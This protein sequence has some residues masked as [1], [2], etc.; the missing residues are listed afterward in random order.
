ML[1][2]RLMEERQ[3]DEIRR[4]NEIVA[5]LWDGDEQVKFSLDTTIYNHSSVAMLELPIQRYYEEDIPL[6]VEAVLNLVNKQ[7]DISPDIF[8][9]LKDIC[10]KFAKDA[11]KPTDEEELA[12]GYV[13]GIDGRLKDDLVEE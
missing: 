9:S 7:K 10:E 3:T 12:H 1:S 2:K 5:Y 6:L 4:K 11:A 8:N 13:V